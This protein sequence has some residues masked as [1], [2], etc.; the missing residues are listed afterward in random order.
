[1]ANGVSE[2]RLDWDSVRTLFTKDP[3]LLR[4]YFIRA[5]AGFRA[6]L[7]RGEGGFFLFRAGAAIE[8]GKEPDADK[9]Y[10]QFARIGFARPD[11]G[12][13]ITCDARPWRPGC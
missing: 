2:M 3:T 4:D 12:C 1:M 5:Q 13:R 6:H 9:A 8:Q 7:L 11:G 10:D